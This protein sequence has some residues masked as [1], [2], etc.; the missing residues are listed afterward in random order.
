M[1][2]AK[3]LTVAIVAM[4]CATGFAL[5]AEED[6]AAGGVTFHIYL[7]M[8]DDT[9]NSLPVNMWLKPYQTES[10]GYESFQAALEYGCREANMDVTML[11][12]TI[13]SIGAYGIHG[14]PDDYS[15]YYGFT[16]YSA[17][18]DKW[19]TVTYAGNTTTYAVVFDKFLSESEYNALSEKD[20]SGYM[21][22]NLLLVKYASKLPNTSV[23]G[24][25]NT[26]LI[27]AGIVAGVIIIAAIVFVV[28]KK[29]A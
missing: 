21:L 9:S 20:K 6:D 22:N 5:M 27:V 26:M 3:F 14:D 28:K 16:I 15:K 10:T 25:D 8:N 4:F 2:K 19:D 7:Q 11:L 18:G 12:G 13:T 17:I 29:H 23:T 24:Y 1:Q